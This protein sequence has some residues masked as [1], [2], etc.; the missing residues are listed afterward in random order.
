M[1]AAHKPRPRILD[2]PRRAQLRTELGAEVRHPKL[3]TVEAQHG[4][5]AG[6]GLV[7]KEYSTL[8]TTDSVPLM[9]VHWQQRHQLAFQLVQPPQL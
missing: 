7:G 1:I 3:A 2:Q 9:P 5:G 4:V 6:D 8:A